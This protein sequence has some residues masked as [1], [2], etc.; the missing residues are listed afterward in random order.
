[1]YKISLSTLVERVADDLYRE[2]VTMGGQWWTSVY[3]VLIS[4]STTSLRESVLAMAFFG[5]SKVHSNG[6]GG[7]AATAKRSHN[8]NLAW[9]KIIQIHN[10]TRRKA[11]LAGKFRSNRLGQFT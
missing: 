10:D 8:Q 9:C 6:L 2:E 1:V 4:L 3:S 11:V 5:L 7:A